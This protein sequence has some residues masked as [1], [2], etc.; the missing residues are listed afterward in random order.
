M[1]HRRAERKASSRYHRLRYD[2][3][4]LLHDCSLNRVDN[5]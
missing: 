2:L 3:F 1:Q 4:K 5:Y